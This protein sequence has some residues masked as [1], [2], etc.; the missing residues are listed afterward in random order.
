MS[1]KSC[2]GAKVVEGGLLGGDGK[3]CWV[4]IHGRVVQVVD[5]W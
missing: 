3:V 2:D 1:L 5:G 4:P